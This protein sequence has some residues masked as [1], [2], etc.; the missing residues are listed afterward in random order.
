M[1][2]FDP[3]HADRTIANDLNRMTAGEREIVYDD[4]HG[5]RNLRMEETTPLKLLECLSLMNDA[6]K[7]IDNKSAYDEACKLKSRY[8][9]RNNQ[10]RIIFL[11]A[12]EYDI[13]KAAQRF[14]NYLDV[15]YNF[16]GTKALMRPIYYNDLEKNDQTHVREG[17]HQLLPCRDRTGRRIMTRIGNMGSPDQSQSTPSVRTYVGC[18]ISCRRRTRHVLCCFLSLSNV[19]K[20]EVFSNHI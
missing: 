11:R 4:I 15:F 13:D 2:D 10:F 12:E 14:V 8:V 19:Y 3:K 17:V 20:Y 1:S 7:R 6:I 5:V 18:Y 9:L 16:F